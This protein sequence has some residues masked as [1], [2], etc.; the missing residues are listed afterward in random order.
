MAVLRISLRSKAFPYLDLS[1]SEK[2]G[3]LKGSLTEPTIWNERLHWKEPYTH[4]Q[5]ENGK[6][7]HIG[8][9]SAWNPYTEWRNTPR[10]DLFNSSI[11]QRKR[12]QDGSPVT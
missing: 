9:R 5:T 4:R 3:W 12:Y 8:G 7:I 10:K 11:P 2:N 1:R 6:N